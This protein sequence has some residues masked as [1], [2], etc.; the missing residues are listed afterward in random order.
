MGINNSVPAS[1]EWT[2]KQMDKYIENIT[3]SFASVEN[4][5][6]LLEIINSLDPNMLS[7]PLK[8]AIL[9]QHKSMI[10]SKS[11][12]D[13]IN[14]SANSF[15]NKLDSS[16]SSTLANNTTINNGLQTLYKKFATVY[17][18]YK[19]FERKYVQMNLFFLIFVN[20]VMSLFRDNNLIYIESLTKQSEL[21][22][23]KLA[24]FIN[25]VA[26]AVPEDI[27]LH[28]DILELGNTVRN[29]I[30]KQTIELR[31]KL[32][33]TNHQQDQLKKIIAQILEVN[34]SLSKPANN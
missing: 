20:N 29:D 34:Q 26:K 32:K 8:N 10:N 2:D 24:A 14:L 13:S 21:F 30:E 12:E 28:D 5:E 16:T 6:D 31:Q 22:K 17:T 3:K 7:Q 33:N 4:T 19:F 23:S 9:K 15:L 18:R 11:L 25:T 1:S 27:S